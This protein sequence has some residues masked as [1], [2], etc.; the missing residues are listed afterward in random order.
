MRIVSIAVDGFVISDGSAE[1][2]V[3]LV[4]LQVEQGVEM[5]IGSII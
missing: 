1:M 4:V 5:C 3:C 2:L